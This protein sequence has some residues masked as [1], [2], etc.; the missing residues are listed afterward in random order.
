VPD[1]AADCAGDAAPSS[2]RDA[3]SV[4]AASAGWDDGS[5]GDTIST[6]MAS[7]GG[8][9]KGFPVSSKAGPRNTT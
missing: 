7:A 3:V 1:G 6:V 4:V 9:S 5:S 8:V 2:F